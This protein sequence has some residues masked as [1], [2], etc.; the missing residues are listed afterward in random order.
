M[1]SAT[2]KQNA[3]NASNRYQFI[4]EIE[5]KWS[6]V[7]IVRSKKCLISNQ[8]PSLEY[9][10][11]HRVIEEARRIKGQVCTVLMA[12][13]V[14]SAHDWTSKNLFR[15]IKYALRLVCLSVCLPDC[16]SSTPSPAE[17][18]DVETWRTRSRVFA[19]YYHFCGRRI[20]RFSEGKRGREGGPDDSQT[21]S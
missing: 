6:G 5:V 16:G 17:C 13:W 19:H 10:Q 8:P 12:M 9:S 21:I 15:S 20:F 11:F 18:E 7:P 3:C 14:R 4:N 1:P 2:N